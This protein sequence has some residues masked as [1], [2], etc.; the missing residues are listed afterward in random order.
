MMQV[1]RN[2][3]KKIKGKNWV[4]PQKNLSKETSVRYILQKKNRGN[5]IN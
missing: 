3:F 1:N 2:I 4:Y 5:Q